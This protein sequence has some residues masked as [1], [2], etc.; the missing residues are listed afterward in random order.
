MDQQKC[1]EKCPYIK[2]PPIWP[3]QVLVHSL[4]TEVHTAEWR[5]A[6]A[7]VNIYDE[8]E[9]ICDNTDTHPVEMPQNADDKQRTS[10]TED[11][12]Q[13]KAE[14]RLLTHGVRLSNF[15]ATNG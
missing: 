10:S 1:S 3:E 12:N 5:Y 7:S 11:K 2:F 13:Q 8:L 14:A 4:I 9:E 6:L 15:I